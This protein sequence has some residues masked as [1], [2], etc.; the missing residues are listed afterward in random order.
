MFY[1]CMH[2]RPMLCKLISMLLICVIPIYAS[3]GVV[4]LSASDDAVLVKQQPN[5]NQGNVPLLKIQPDKETQRALVKFDFANYSITSSDVASAMLSMHV[6]FNDGNFENR[7]SAADI[8]LHRMQESWHERDVTWQCD[9][10]SER[11]VGGHFS[12]KET[13]RVKVSDITSGTIQFDVTKDVKAWLNNKEDNN[14]WLIKK[15]RESKDGVI[16]FSSKEGSHAPK[17]ILSLDTLSDV[18]PPSVSIVTPAGGLLISDKAPIFNAIYTDDTSINEADVLIVLD[19]ALDVGSHCSISQSASSC[20][21]TGLMPGIHALEV[22]VWDSVG[23]ASSD[24]L[25]FLY[26]DTANHDGFASKWHTG[27]GLPDSAL[28]GNSDLYLNENNAD[29][30]KKENGSWLLSLNIQGS[31]GLQGLQGQKGDL[32][33]K[34]DTG[35]IGLKGEKGEQG[36]QGIPGLVGLKGDTG[37][38]GIAGEIGQTGDKGDQGDAGAKY[39]SVSCI[40]DER[41]I[42]FGEHGQLIC[43]VVDTGG[44]GDNVGKLLGK[45]NDT[46]MDVCWR[47]EDSNLYACPQNIV[48]HGQDGDYGRDVLAQN[49]DLIKE[50]SGPAGFDLTKV[51]MQGNDLPE[52]AENWRCLRDNVTGLIWEVK[53]NQ[54][55]VPK[56]QYAFEYYWYNSDEGDVFTGVKP[57][58]GSCGGIDCN[59]EAYVMAINALSLC[60]INAWHVPTVHELHSVIDYGYSLD[61]EP[62]MRGLSINSFKQWSK[63]F[64]GRF[65][66]SSHHK[67]QHNLVDSFSGLVTLG[68]RAEKTAKLILVT[69]GK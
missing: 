44:N 37:P 2:C 6:E 47:E 18:A 1:K 39:V 14:G 9:H 11:W 21:L 13:D 19:D 68:D 32:G 5:L 3:A 36:L 29:V 62:Y 54:N 64:N 67:G 57:P 27:S 42:G 12:S 30:Y 46:G 15:D 4:V 58:P 52:G 65:W 34:G 7:G 69:G 16:V 45:L 43:G 20:T 63:Y 61:S 59:T 28:G 50:G 24:T 10:C 22:A 26:L 66:T 41:V 56:L 49:G 17:L 48:I 23:N 51:D 25:N 35:E 53:S 40:G 60:G 31:Q 55:D 8:R 33:L 38:Q